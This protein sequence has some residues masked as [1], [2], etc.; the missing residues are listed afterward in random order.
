MTPAGGGSSSLPVAR[1]GPA[2][3]AE[4]RFAQRPARRPERLVDPMSE[5]GLCPGFA[6]PAE[7]GGWKANE[8]AFCQV[9]LDRPQRHAPPAE[10]GADKAVLGILA[11]H[12]PGARREDAEV[13]LA[14]E[15]SR[16]L[17]DDLQG[18]VACHARTCC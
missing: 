5:I 15:R 16:I 11:A 2:G 14:G 3:A 8:P 1:P 7:G 17:E 18:P 13:T 4:Q 9:V 6:L 12:P 10:P